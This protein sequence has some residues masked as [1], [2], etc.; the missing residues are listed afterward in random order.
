MES[1]AP[2]SLQ[3]VVLYGGDSPGRE[4]SLASGRC[5]A[6]ALQAAGHDVSLIDPAETSIETVDWHNVDVCFIALHGG[7]GEDGRIQQ[8]LEQQGVRYTGSGPAAS[9]LAMSKLA[10]KQRFRAAGI[11]TPQFVPIEP[12]DTAARVADKVAR[13]GYPLIVKPDEQGSSLGVEVV[14]E[15]AQ[16]AAAMDHSRQFGPR[17]LAERLVVGRELTIS[18][19]GRRALP[20]LEIVSPDG[21]FD[22]QAKYRSPDTEYRF[23]TG[24]SQAV[25]S[26]VSQTALAAAEALQTRGLVRV[27]V[28]LDSEDRPWVLEVNT[29][30]G[31]TERS[32]SPK[33][34]AE[35]GLDMPRLCDWIVRDALPEI[36]GEIRD[37]HFAAL[38]GE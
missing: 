8:R 37:D 9:R 5:V 3:L 23:R 26:R 25:L 16:L 30:P 12:S 35:A 11:A 27:D 4:I 20:V 24:L 32:L 13:L 7:A 21:L 14:M 6:S 38:A 31:M 2:A 15:S 33:A 36:V 28:I 18:I 19:L 34:A 22:Y 10:G 1:Y 17:A 29:V